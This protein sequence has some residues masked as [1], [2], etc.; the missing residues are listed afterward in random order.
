M[1][2]NSKNGESD[3]ATDIPLEGRYN[4]KFNTVDEHESEV[5]EDVTTPVITT[6][7]TTPFVPVYVDECRLPYEPANDPDG[8]MGWRFGLYFFLFLRNETLNN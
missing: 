7:S 4:E 8:A 3:S 1:K 2:I 6:K 5:D